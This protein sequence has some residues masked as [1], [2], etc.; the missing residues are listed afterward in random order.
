MSNCDAKYFKTVMQSTL[1]SNAKSCQTVMP[2]IAN[3]KAKYGQAEMP[4][5]FKLPVQAIVR[6]LFDCCNAKMCCVVAHSTNTVQRCNRQVEVGG[7][8]PGRQI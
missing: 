5:T 4:S 7:S 8:V 3:C 2:S 1:N 6:E